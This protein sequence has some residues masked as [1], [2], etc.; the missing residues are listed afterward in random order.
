M[1]QAAEARKRGKARTGLS[2]EDLLRAYRD[3]AKRIDPGL[4]KLFKTLPR[5]PYGVIAVPAYAE[6]SQTTTRSP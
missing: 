4:V 1:A 5:L 3:I 2:E 6:K